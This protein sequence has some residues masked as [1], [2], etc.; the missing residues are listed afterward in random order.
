MTHE[1]TLDQEV[2]Q[3]ES[4]GPEDLLGGLV[5]VGAHAPVR[6]EVFAVVNHF[7]VLALAAGNELVIERAGT[8]DGLDLP[9]GPLGLRDAGWLQDGFE[10]SVEILDGMSLRGLF[11]PS[12]SLSSDL[13]EGRRRGKTRRF[14]SLLGIVTQQLW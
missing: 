3:V 14:C 5:S 1:A 8:R 10:L 11:L 7:K 2:I 4:A 13:E 9:A 6:E 12:S